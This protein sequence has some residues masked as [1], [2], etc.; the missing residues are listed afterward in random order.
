MA[1]DGAPPTYVSTPYGMVTAA[2]RWYHIPEEQARAYAGEVL[3][4][5]SLEDLVERAD[6]WIESPRTVTLWLLP[7]LLW[8]LSSLW[9]VVGATGLYLGWALASP[10]VPS[11]WGTRAVNLLSSTL[12]Q[13]GYYAV[14]LSLF[15][16][17]DRFAAVGVGLAAFVLFRW[18]IVDWAVR[19]ALRALRRRLYPL[20]VTDQILRGLMVRAALKHRVSVP[21]V[22]AITQDILDNWG[23]RTDAD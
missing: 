8:G 9:A 20:P 2:G 17:D 14:V 15:A 10:A 1:S 11:L 12:A 5:V 22:D 21:Q 19:G 18:G 6:L 23:A 13:G 3:K 7:L 4:H 16:M